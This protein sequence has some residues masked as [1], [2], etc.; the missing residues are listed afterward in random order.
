MPLVRRRPLLRAAAIGGGAYVAGKRRN[1][2]EQREA[3]EQARIAQLE[4]ERQPAPPPTP[5]PAP[6]Q[7]AAPPAAAGGITDDA[8]ARL[9]RLGKLR[10][11]GVLTDEEF[12]R[13]KAELLGG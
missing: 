8:L 3:D 6:V 2:A 10:E 7:A 12:A 4:A 9:E 1:E 11:Q 13:Q 5:A